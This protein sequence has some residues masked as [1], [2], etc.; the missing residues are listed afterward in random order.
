MVPDVEVPAARWGGGGDRTGGDRA[1]YFRDQTEH[2]GAGGG[3]ATASGPCGEFA[4]GGNR[5]DRKVPHRAVGGADASD[6]RVDGGG[7][8]GP[9]SAGNRAGASRRHAAG[10]GGVGPAAGWPG[11]AK[12]LPQPEPDEGRRGAA[13]RLEQ[14]G[15]ARRGGAGGVGD[16]V[17]GRRD[18]ECAGA[19]DDPRERAAISHD[20][21]RDEHGLCPRG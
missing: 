19:G 11:R 2:G 4:A 15:V 13:L 12:S 16:L 18:G 21:R 9:A 7:G 20:H 3:A 6:V 17:R 10:A 8:D 5:V 1:R 14:L